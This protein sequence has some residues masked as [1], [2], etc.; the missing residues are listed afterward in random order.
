MGLSLSDGQSKMQQLMRYFDHNA[1]TGLDPQVLEAMLPFLQT[2]WAN[3]S[4]AYQ[5]A[6]PVKRAL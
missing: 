2:H 3:P 6:R 5:F 4:S 1:T